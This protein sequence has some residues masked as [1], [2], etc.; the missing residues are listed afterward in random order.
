MSKIR[1]LVVYPKTLT[2]LY[3]IKADY[4][5]IGREVDIQK[6]EIGDKLIVLALPRKYK[7]KNDIEAKLKEKREAYED[8]EF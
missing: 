5:A 7:K 4:E 6:D 1:N 3:S 8:K 2:E